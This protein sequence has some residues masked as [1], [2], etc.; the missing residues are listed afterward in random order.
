MS[1]VNRSA[2]S[3]VVGW[4]QSLADII[5]LALIIS[6]VLSDQVDLVASGPTAKSDTGPA[7]ALEVLRELDP[8]LRKVP[9]SILRHLERASAKPV[10]IPENVSNHLI[11]NIHVAVRACQTELE[12]AGFEVLTEVQSD[13]FETAEA[14]GARLA[15]WLVDRGDADHPI[16]LVSGGE[17]VVKLCR[18]PGKGGRNQQLVLAALTELTERMKSD[19]DSRSRLESVEETVEFALLSGG[20]DGEDG[21]TSVAGAYLSNEVLQNA[22]RQTANPASYLKR[23]DSFT[24]FDGV[25]AGPFLNSPPRIETNVCDLRVI[26]ISPKKKG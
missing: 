6:D 3:K 2:K 7:D 19:A 9:K 12:A 22:K 18:N 26:A 23:N 16:A 10:V 24:F 4:Q 11:G 5:W 17:P 14:A 13:E 21:S 1:S 15:K 20:T 25:L 8:K